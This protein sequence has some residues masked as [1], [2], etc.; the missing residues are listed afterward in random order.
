VAVEKIASGLL[1][2]QF[3]DRVK[4]EQAAH[5]AATGFELCRAI[6]CSGLAVFPRPEERRKCESSLFS[7]RL[8]RSS[9]EITTRKF[10]QEKDSCHVLSTL[11]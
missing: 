4:H 10:A 8:V 3:A 1:E 2:R 9:S 11:C 6:S 7:V 5:E